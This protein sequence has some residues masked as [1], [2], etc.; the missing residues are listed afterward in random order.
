MVLV[1]YSMFFYRGNTIIEKN[2]GNTSTVVV[3]IRISA[4]VKC[5]PNVASMIKGPISEIIRLA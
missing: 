4:V 3:L 2:I 5:S 1:N